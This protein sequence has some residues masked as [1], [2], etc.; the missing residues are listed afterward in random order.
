MST[1]SLEFIL[2]GPIEDLLWMRL[3]HPTQC[4]EFQ[5]KN[6]QKW[7]KITS[8]QGH[9]GSMKVNKIPE[10]THPCSQ[11]LEYVLPIVEKK[12]LFFK[13]R[14]DRCFSFQFSSKF[15]KRKKLTP[16]KSLGSVSPH[17][18]PVKNILQ[19]QQM[20]RINKKVGSLKN[21]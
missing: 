3:L 9:A 18:L 12:K 19:H 8:I 17:S 20:K 15:T 16:S 13:I 1:F 4:P 10:K 11:S 21:K 6:Y 2:S 14:L 7:L 5:K